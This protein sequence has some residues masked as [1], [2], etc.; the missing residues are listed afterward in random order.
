MAA[1]AAL[2]ERGL[3][4]VL[5]EQRKAL[6][7]RASSFHDPRAGCWVDHGR[8]ALMGCCTNALDLIGRANLTPYFQRERVMNF[9]DARG[10]LHPFRPGRMLPAPLHLL[11]ALW[12]L[13]ML[14][15]GERVGMART[16]RRLAG[17]R[18]TAS[19]CRQDAETWLRWRGESDHAIEQFWTPLLVSALSETLDRIALP[20]ARN[21][22][23]EGLLLA[24]GASDLYWPTTSLHE[25]FHEAMGRWLESLGVEIRLPSRVASVEIGVP[26]EDAPAGRVDV[27]E[28]PGPAAPRRRVTALRFG[29]D[30]KAE[31]VDFCILAVPW[32]RVRSLLPAE[33]L[34]W[35]PELA[36]WHRYEPAPITAVHLWFDRPITRVPHAVLPGRTSQW[37]FRLPAVA[38]A[39]AEG[40]RNADGEDGRA[41]EPW[42]HYQVLISAAHS[43]A[44]MPR[45]ELLRRVTAELRVLGKEAREARLMHHRVST[46]PLAVFSPR[47]GLEPYRPGP[48]TPADNLFL[49]GDWTD[50]GWP[51]T[52]ESAVRSGRIAAGRVLDCLGR[53]EELLTPDMSPSW[54]ARL[55]LGP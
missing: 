32:H 39:G 51:S 24:R 45:D 8:H 9:V 6:G 23:R 13:R 46:S 22:C 41:T 20:A 50:T 38:G 15:P 25:V 14:P 1:A 52:I 18:L 37:L 43:A 3:H 19:E 48:N 26:D 7:G 27:V 54:L 53:G 12:Q 16:M 21:V 11:G 47:P 36:V 34:A 35:M 33:L 55:M 49:A 42:S 5:H 30:K 31:P 4:V 28:G 29:A 10:R 2:A 44:E 40:N 17:R